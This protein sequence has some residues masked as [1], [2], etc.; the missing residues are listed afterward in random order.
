DKGNFV[1]SDNY[2]NRGLAT[3]E[4]NATAWGQWYNG[5]LVSGLGTNGTTTSY[6]IG[7]SS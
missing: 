4:A 3:D 2:K 6:T 7:W 5:Y 1:W